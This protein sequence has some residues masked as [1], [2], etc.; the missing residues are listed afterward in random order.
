MG[1]RRFGNVPPHQNFRFSVHNA[2]DVEP[3]GL[4]AV[5]CFGDK[6]KGM[7]IRHPHVVS[8]NSVI[9]AFYIWE[10]FIYTSFF[11]ISEKLYDGREQFVGKPSEGSL[12]CHKGQIFG[13]FVV[14]IDPRQPV[15]VGNGKLCVAQIQRIKALRYFGRYD[16]TAFV[17]A[18]ATVHKTLEVV[19]LVRLILAVQDIPAQSDVVFRKIRPAK[20][21]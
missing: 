21:L 7:V 20:P 9:K 19:V 6:V 1:V 15:A 8:F 17:P 4:F 3:V 5:V 18:A 12:A 11:S 16:R 13:T 14:Y 2:R 10:T